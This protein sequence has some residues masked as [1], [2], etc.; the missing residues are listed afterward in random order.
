MMIDVY[1]KGK[2]PKC[3]EE[4][5]FPIFSGKEEDWNKSE[6]KYWELEIINGNKSIVCGNC[7]KVFFLQQSYPHFYILDAGTSPEK[8]FFDD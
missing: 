4:T 3:K 2:C 8:G 7:G 5:V 6:K 1:I